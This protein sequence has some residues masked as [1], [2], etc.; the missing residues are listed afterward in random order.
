MPASPEPD[1]LSPLSLAGVSLAED[2]LSVVLVVF[3][4]VVDVDVVCAAAA[5]ALVFVGG[6]ISGVLLGTGSETLLPPHALNASAQSSVAP[7]ASAARVLTT[8][9]CAFRTWGSR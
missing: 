7:V 6:E 8:G 9:P 4:A 2:E 3:V 5:S 1:E